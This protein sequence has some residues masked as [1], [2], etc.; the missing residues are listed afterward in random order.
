ILKLRELADRLRDLRDAVKAE[1][2]EARLKGVRDQA[3]R[4]LRD[5]SELFEEGGDVI[6]LGNRHKFSVNTQPLDLTLLPRADALALHL[7]G[8]DFLEPIEDEELAS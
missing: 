1:D 7:T 3:L 6:R 4:A 2:V 5:R 8:T